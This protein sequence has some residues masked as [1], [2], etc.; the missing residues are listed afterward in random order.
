MWS[1]A[2]LSI[3]VVGALFGRTGG[4]SLAKKCDLK[5][6][7]FAL[8]SVTILRGGDSEHQVIGEEVIHSNWR[9]VINR[10]V[11]LPNKMILD[12][13]IVSQGDRGGKVSDEAVLVFVW[14]TA[15]K[16][17]VLVR[18]YMPSV[19]GFLNGLAAGMVEDKHGNET[20]YDNIRTA[21]MHEL[22]EEC[23]LIGGEWYRL[24]EPTVMDK[25][26]TTRL[27]VYLVIDPFE[28]HADEAKPRDEAE[29]GMEVVKGVTPSKLFRS[30]QT[31]SMT[32]VGAW[33]TQLA[34][35]KLRE[36]GEIR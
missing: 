33:A 25:Y 7:D 32:V 31:G 15:T 13:E 14:N 4:F 11:R 19:N 24:C 30:I 34:L 2:V 20:D 10:T 21:A 1:R 12:F 27:S 28:I 8:R 18:E 5:N 29:E 6:Q 3:L 9:K 23:R 17:A 26:T 35:N 22:E 16:T 36:L